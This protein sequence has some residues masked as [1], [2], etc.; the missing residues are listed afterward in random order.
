MGGPT[1]RGMSKA[2]VTKFYQKA[3]ILGGMSIEES[4]K[5]SFH[6]VRRAHVTFA[7]NY[8][9]ASDGTVALG[10]KHAQAGNVPHY[11]DASRAQLT[12]SAQFQGE[13][14]DKM[15]AV[16]AM[17][18]IP[19]E[20][21]SQVLQPVTTMKIPGEVLLSSVRVSQQRF[22]FLTIFYLQRELEKLSYVRL[23]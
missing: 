5:Y 11:N 16:I 1:H 8:G 6:G 13:L 12:I 3:L 21:R 2:N 23:R 19:E 17:K 15:R 4:R 22:I 10:T 20:K 14:R 7:K 9:Q 18:A